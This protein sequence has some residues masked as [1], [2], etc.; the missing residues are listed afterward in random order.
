[1]TAAANAKPIPVLPDVGSINVSLRKNKKTK[2][3]KQK[4]NSPREL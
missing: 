2:S 3:E 1:L 4:N